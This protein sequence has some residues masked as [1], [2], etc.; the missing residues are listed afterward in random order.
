[1]IERNTMRKGYIKVNN[2]KEGESIEIKMRRII[3]NKEGV[4]NVSP[5]TYTERAAGVIPEMN[6]RTDRFELAQEAMGE[7]NKRKGAIKKNLDLDR[8][9]KEEKKENLEQSSDNM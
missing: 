8:I 4:E 2:S 7:V 6:I 5:M 1:M 3:E 9:I